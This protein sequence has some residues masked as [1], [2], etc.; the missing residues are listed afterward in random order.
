MRDSSPPARFSP[1]Q[2]ACVLRFFAH[3]VPHAR[4]GAAARLAPRRSVPLCP[5]RSAC[6]ALGRSLAGK[7]A[8]SQRHRVAQLSTSALSQRHPIAQLCT[9][10]LS[11][12]HRV[13]QLSTSALSQRRRIAQL[14]WAWAAQDPALAMAAF[15]AMPQQMYYVPG[16]PGTMS[17][18]APLSAQA[19]ARV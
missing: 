14:S 4:T 19:G 8:F 10:A 6:G 1:L 2:S 11:Q 12:R 13:A 9:S 7:G 18:M 15:G 17:L 5:R 3:C 16:Q